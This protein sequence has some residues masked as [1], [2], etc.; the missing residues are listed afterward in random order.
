MKRRLFIGL[1]VLGGCA[2]YQSISVTPSPKPPPISPPPEPRPSMPN[3][4]SGNVGVAGATLVL[5]NFP[6]SGFLSTTADG[7]GNY[8]FAAL[9]AGTY[10]LSV[11]LTG[12]TF[13]PATATLTIVSTNLTQNFTAT[14]FTATGV[15][16]K[17]GDINLIAPINARSTISGTASGTVIL[18]GNPKILAGTKVF[19]SWFIDGVNTYYAESLDGITWSRQGGAIVSG[20]SNPNVKLINGTYYLTGSLGNPG[21]IAVYTASNSNGPF[22][23]QNAS[24]IAAGAAGQWDSGGCFQLQIVDQIGGTWYGIYTALSASLTGGNFIISLGLATSPDLITWTKSGSNPVF[25]TASSPEIHKVN[26]I[27][28]MWYNGVPYDKS[29][30]LSA[31]IFGPTDIWRAQSTDLI[32]WTNAQPSLLRSHI[33]EGVGMPKGAMVNPTL[34]VGSNSVYMFY[35]GTNNA[36]TNQNLKFMLATANMGIQQLVQTNEGLLS[37][38]QLAIDTFQRGNENPLSNGGKWSVLGNAV[39]LLSNQAISSATGVF[40]DAGYTGISWPNDQYNEAV[41]TTLTGASTRQ[42]DLIVRYNGTSDYDLVI[43][44]TLGVS[45]TV[46]LIIAGGATIGTATLTPISLDVWRIEAKGTRVN[47]YQNGVVVITAVDSS[48]VAG[49]PYI[50]T[51]NDA[52]VANTA[53][54]AWEGGSPTPAT[55]PGI[56]NG[57]TSGGSAFDIAFRGRLYVTR[58]VSG[59]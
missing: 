11:A 45:Q 24:A 58:V 34:V 56:P 30:G 39:Q 26:G 20:M 52:A 53:Y 46:N 6:T 57:V 18:E 54:G 28:Y 47:V 3:T 5:A 4:I 48:Q 50:Q 12:F 37:S 2:S 17:Y 49:T 16:T 38:P 41:L 31:A 8:S 36:N 29:V 13:A 42:A 51:R 21:T 33:G 19:K 23:Q 10:Y 9:G 44:N 43:N 55:L 1:I 32:N 7:S 15:W 27:Y 25:Y 22:T 14:A 35:A 40:C 59:L